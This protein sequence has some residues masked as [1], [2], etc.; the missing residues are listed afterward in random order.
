M[1]EQE[2]IRKE[3]LIEAQREGGKKR[4]QFLQSQG[5]QNLIKY[6]ARIKYPECKRS[7]LSLDDLEDI[8]YEGAWE[9]VDRYDGQEDHISFMRGKIIAQI[10]TQKRGQKS[11]DGP[12]LDEDN[13][14]GERG[15]REPP[16]P[17]TATP[18]VER[19]IVLERVKA[20]LGELGEN[21]LVE[22]WAGRTEEEILK[23]WKCKGSDIEKVKNFACYILDEPK[24]I[25]TR[26]AKE[27]LHRKKGLLIEDDKKLARSLIEDFC[28][29]SV[30]I[31]WKEYSDDAALLLSDPEKIKKYD[32]AI[33]DLN[34]PR[35]KGGK[36]TPLA[37]EAL[38]PLLAKPDMPPGVI[39]STLLCLDKPG[40]LTPKQVQKLMKD[41][42]LHF[43]PL[44]KIPSYSKDEEWHYDFDE[45][46]RHLA[47]IIPPEPSG[48][49][50][51]AKKGVLKALET[52][53]YWIPEERFTITNKLWKEID[54]RRIEIITTKRQRELLKKFR[55]IGRSLEYRDVDQIIRDYSTKKEPDMKRGRITL[56]SEINKALDGTGLRLKA[57]RGDKKV[58]LIEE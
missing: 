13:R 28:A 53:T 45:L 52:E 35:F 56:F 37:G 49:S 18:W 40:N 25:S 17:D 9:A 38:L 39:L 19:H 50:I 10:D 33:V 12:F 22:L 48:H 55:D 16:V 20:K 31:E 26:E 41:L 46:C 57:I 58:K 14:E 11:H 21:I 51:K 36:P 34:L 29:I 24:D 5:V 42:M 15:F 30:E 6:W 27:S 1:A 47:A 32:F 43:D 44:N 54:D 23:K 2:E 3:D 8:G 4:D 7:G